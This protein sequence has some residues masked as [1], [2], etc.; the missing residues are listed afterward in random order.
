MKTVLPPIILIPGMQC[1]ES[2]F[3][4]IIHRLWTLMPEARLEVHLLHQTGLDAAVSALMA[5][6]DQPAILVGHSLGGTVAMALARRFPERVAGLALVCASPRPPRPTQLTYWTSLL[7]RL[8]DGDLVGIVDE[9]VPSL[10]GSTTASA[11]AA[12][13]Y[14]TCRR[15]ALNTGAPGLAG[16]LRIQLDRVDE[17]PALGSY[18]GPLLAMA[19]DDDCLVPSAAVREISASTPRGEFALIPRATHM[20]PLTMPGT[21]ASTIGSWLHKN[22]SHPG[23]NAFTTETQKVE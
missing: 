14:Q 10:V 18:A 21:V 8:K 6:I 16:Q 23:I 22:F 4:G 3:E 7:R 19:A 15:M 1:D 9:I 17:R 12:N 20:A 2:M 5:R 11:Y 13:H